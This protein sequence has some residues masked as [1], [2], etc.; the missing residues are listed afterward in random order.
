MAMFEQKSKGQV[1][2]PNDPAERASASDSLMETVSKINDEGQRRAATMR[3]LRAYLNELPS[4]SALVRAVVA[5][6]GLDA[7]NGAAAVEAM[8]KLVQFRDKAVDSFVNQATKKAAE[9][10]F[11]L[12][13]DIPG[14]KSL[15]TRSIS[16]E[17]ANTWVQSRGK[18]IYTSR[19]AMYLEYAVRVLSEQH[20]NEAPAPGIECLSIDAVMALNKSTQQIENALNEFIERSQLP[21]KGLSFL[22]GDDNHSDPFVV[23]QVVMDRVIR[24]LTDV[25]CKSVIEYVAAGDISNRDQQTL[26][27]SVL[28]QLTQDSVMAL[29]YQASTMLKQVMGKP[30]D[31]RRALQ[32]ENGALV[33]WLRAELERRMPALFMV[34]EGYFQ[35][36]T[37]PSKSNQE[38]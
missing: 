17:M 21:T 30:R 7:Q 37:A 26:F 3:R 27:K 10:D 5:Y 4:S 23:A 32:R 1:F 2:N 31:Q 22:M 11:T 20:P 36:Q 13:F 19:M 25:G 29:R 38:D 28:F 33:Q 15:I 24:P 9:F 34:P 12:D 14:A 35:T 18:D 8:Q 16:E 6:P